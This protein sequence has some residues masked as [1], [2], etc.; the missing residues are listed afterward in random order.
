MKDQVD[1][2]RKRGVSAALVSS[3]CDAESEEMKTGVIEGRYEL[4]SISPEQL[5]GN[6]RF[7]C[8]CRNECYVDKLVAFVVDEAH[9]VKKW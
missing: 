9:C 8:M 7:R 5:I 1:S 2:F 6:K 4:V 3:D